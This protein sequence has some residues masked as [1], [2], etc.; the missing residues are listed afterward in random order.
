MPLHEDSEI[1]SEFRSMPFRPKFSRSRSSGGKPVD[2]AEL[3]R[4]FMAK[5]S[6]ALKSPIKTISENWAACVPQKFASKS[7]PINFRAG[8]VYAD[9]ANAQVRQ[10]LQFVERSILRKIKALEGCSS[11]KSIRFV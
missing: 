2:S 10:E 8:V 4:R 5:F 9:A 3:T 1:L 6:V 11:V 7:A